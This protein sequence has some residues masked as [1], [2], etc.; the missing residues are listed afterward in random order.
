[1]TKLIE[2]QLPYSPSITIRLVG[3]SDAVLDFIGQT[4]RGEKTSPILISSQVN[5][6]WELEQPTEDYW[7]S[8][9]EIYDSVPANRGS[10]PPAFGEG[11][12]YLLHPGLTPYLDELPAWL[13]ENLVYPVPGLLNE[14]ALLPVEAAEHWRLAASNL[15]ILQELKDEFL[16]PDGLSRMTYEPEALARGATPTR[17]VDGFLL[18]SVDNGNSE[19]RRYEIKDK[20]SNGDFLH[21]YTLSN[22]SGKTKVGILVSAGKARLKVESIAINAAGMPNVQTIKGP[23]DK[24]ADISPWAVT[25]EET[26][27]VDEMGVYIRNISTNGQ[28]CIYTLTNE[29]REQSVALTPNTG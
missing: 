13:Q 16:K 28:R 19:C 7:N 24:A 6:E 1:M 21:Y 25:I 4:T 8:L 20:Q 11:K 14:G 23:N 12:G 26:D 9:Q 3:T 2:A 15:R 10:E 18:V 27:I 17:K 5:S 22:I 29:C